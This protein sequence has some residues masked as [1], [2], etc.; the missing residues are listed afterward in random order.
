MKKIEKILHSLAL[1][2]ARTYY[3]GG[4]VRDEL[5]NI[6]SK[7]IDIEI[8]NVSE[9]TFIKIMLALNIHMDFVGE[10]FGVYKTKLDGYEYD[11]SFPRTEIKTGDKHTDFKIIVDPFIG[12]Y[13]A[14]LRRD[15]TI[16]ALMKNTQTGEIL[17]FHHG[18]DDLNNGIIRH[19]SNKFSEDGLRIYRAAQ[20]AA[21][22]GFKIDESTKQLFVPNLVQNLAIERVHM[23]L[24]KV[25]HKAEKPS[26]FFNHLPDEIL[27]VHFNNIIS[28]KNIICNALD[29]LAKY[30]DNKYYELAFFTILCTSSNEKSNL[31]INE[32]Q[33]VK[34]INNFDYAK[35][36][37]LLP[38]NNAD[39]KLYKIFKY[40]DK[41]GYTGILILKAFTPHLDLKYDSE[42][43]RYNNIIQNLVS[44]KDLIALGYKPDA[45]FSQIINKMKDNLFK[46]IAHPFALNNAIETIYEVNSNDNQIY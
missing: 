34:F 15:F 13:K 38:Y 35:L 3:V 24:Q 20:F 27:A 9:K 37:E 18:I 39:Y 44:G 21:R 33:I 40:I 29:N 36:L 7:D 28:I 1:A 30:K 4:C 22:F 23:E 41:Y 42:F 12:E 16:N 32:K 6:N 17:D 8:H 19:T 45:R 46:G 31:I 26:V 2:W 43:R 14:S 25:I 11:F 5:L 10:S